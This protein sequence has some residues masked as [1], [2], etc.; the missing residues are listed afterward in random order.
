MRVIEFQPIFVSFMSDE[1]TS[2]YF[3]IESCSC[4][5]ISNAQFSKLRYMAS[6]HI[7]R[8]D[9][10][11]SDGIFI[12]LNCIRRIINSVTYELYADVIGFAVSLRHRHR[13]WLWSLPFHYK[14]L[15]IL[16][17]HTRNAHTHK[18]FVNCFKRLNLKLEHN[19]HTEVCVHWMFCIQIHVSSNKK[20]NWKPFICRSNKL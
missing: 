11:L 19:K 12:G 6:C 5:G 7:S 2:I 20:P 3:T 14:L 16:C 8:I 1:I 10:S 13:H 17:I 15:L 18:R 4:F 9:L